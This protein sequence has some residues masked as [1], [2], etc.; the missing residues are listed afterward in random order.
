MSLPLALRSGLRRHGIVDSR[1]LPRPCP[2]ADLV[3]VFIF[4]F[5]FIV[6]F[7]VVF[8]VRGLHIHH[9]DD[10]TFAVGFHGYNMLLLFGSD[11]VG[12]AAF[13]SVIVLASERVGFFVVFFR[14]LFAGIGS[15]LAAVKHSP[16]LRHG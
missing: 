7:A 11:L 1:D 5:I 12:I 8:V 4:V 15:G 9:R 6:I 10:R 14:V 16:V 3:F 2:S 13:V